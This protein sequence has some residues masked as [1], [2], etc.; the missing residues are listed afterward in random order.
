MK[1]LTNH[2]CIFNKF[3]KVLLRKQAELFFI[4]INVD[5]RFVTIY[6]FSLYLFLFPSLL[7]WCSFPHF[8]F[9]FLPILVCM[10]YSKSP[11]QMEVYMPLLSQFYH[12]TQIGRR[13]AEWVPVS[14]VPCFDTFQFVHCHKCKYDSNQAC[15]F[16]VWSGAA[17]ACCI[18]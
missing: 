15:M 2:F 5:L 3:R 4:N 6:F 18:A 12:R 16:L 1:S 14:S 13:A 10:C 7:L 11:I 17:V 8:F 9:S